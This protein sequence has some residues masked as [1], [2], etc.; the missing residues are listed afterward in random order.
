MLPV[1]AAEC[2]DE[3]NLKLSQ[4]PLSADGSKKPEM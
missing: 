1:S 3:G 2:A 4:G